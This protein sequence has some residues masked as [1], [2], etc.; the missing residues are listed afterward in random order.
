MLRLHT[1]EIKNA[2]IVQ[3]TTIS[4]VRELIAIT[5]I[6]AVTIAMIETRKEITEKKLN[7]KF[8]QII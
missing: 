2:H 4:Y 1:L 5:S 6:S 8:N 7:D 3:L